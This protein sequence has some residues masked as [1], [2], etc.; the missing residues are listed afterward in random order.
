MPEKPRQLGKYLLLDVIGM[1]S[2]ARVY[3][4]V[5]SGLLGFRKQV[6]VKQIL[7]HVLEDKN[8]IR[9]IINEA[10]LGGYLHHRN[11]VEMYEFDQEGRSFFIAMEFVPGH[12]LKQVL[13]LTP[14]LGK[15]PPP[16]IAEITL[17]LCHGLAYAH[18]ACDDSGQPLNLIHRDL[19][20]GNVMITP[21]GV[22]KLM[23]FGVA[24]SEANLF[25][26][27]V[28]NVTRGT[29]AYMSPDQVRGM[30]LDRRSDL[31]SLGSVMAEMITGRKLF[32]DTNRHALL[33]K[34]EAAAVE[35][36]LGEVDSRMPLVS[37]ILRKALQRERDQRYNSAE[38]M[39][40]DVTQ[41][42]ADLL[43]REN[44]GNWLVAW[45]EAAAS[46]PEPS[47]PGGTTQLEVPT[48]AAAATSPDSEIERSLTIEID[49]DDPEQGGEEA[50]ERQPLPVARV[51]TTVVIPGECEKPSQLEMVMVRFEPGTFWMGSRQDDPD[52]SPDEFLHRVQISR[53][54]LL[55]TTPLTQAQ[56]SALM[57]EN[58][59]WNKGDDL[60]VESIRWHD[61]A[62]FCNR[63][64]EALGFRP[65]YRLEHGSVTWNH[66]ADGFRL[67]SE[68]EWEFAARSGEE[69]VFAGSN[70]PDEVAWHWNNAEGVIKPVAGLKPTAS[71][72]YDMSGNVAEWVWDRY[73]P[74]PAESVV[75]DP[76]GQA[77]GE[78]RV[79]RGGSAFSIA[80]DVRVAARYANAH[81]DERYFFLGFRPARTILGRSGMEDTQ[82]LDMG[83]EAPTSLVADDDTAPTPVPV[84][85]KGGK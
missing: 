81:Q 26:T 12:S 52:G 28:E 78:M 5:Q 21:D 76:S 40:D 51:S 44:L 46:P 49:L 19:K 71:G 80:S 64:S 8:A 17:Q 57:G 53:P 85:K 82:S 9:G 67:P 74:Y 47:E 59:S 22:V 37:P 41:A 35:G 84:L 68:A 29:P 55:A 69:Y 36:A 73:G 16:I 56:W 31:F 4:A 13:A 61:A 43:G 65:A 75:V 30:T 27:Q 18:A 2:Y 3:R 23:D 48:Q 15:L 62:Q 58:P 83:K 6:A 63:L 77:K 14:V 42:C 1:G 7:P 32:S 60:P 72:M 38:E 39:G 54:F 66:S 24:K 34:V 45:M 11:L 50:G 20:P 25:H 33:A 10:R 70:D 79:C